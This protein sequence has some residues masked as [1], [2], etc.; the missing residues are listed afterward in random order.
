MSKYEL[1]EKDFE[2][3]FQAPFEAY[4]SDSPYVSL[5]KPDLERFLNKKENPL[6]SKYGDFTYFVVYRDQRPVGRIVAHIHHSSNERHSLKWSYFGFF[7]CDQDPQVAKMLLE[8]AENWGRAQGAKEIVGNMN[9][10]AMQQIGVMTDL[11]ENAP[12]S[13][14]V[15][16]PAHI[17]SH[18]ESH[19]YGKFFPSTTF[20]LDLTQFDS[21]SLLKGR[22]ATLKE[23]GT[24]QLKTPSR[25]GLAKYLE[26][27]RLVLN[28]GF[29]KNPFF[30][31]VTAE[32][33][34]FQAKDMMWVIDP[35]ITT[36]AYQGE[37]PVG[38]VICIPDLNPLLKATESRLSWKILSHYFRFRMNRKRA[39]IIYYSVTPDNHGQ[40]TA[41]L[42]LYE[43]V[44][45]LKASGY[46]KLAFTWIADE[47]IGSIRQTERLGAKPLHRL[48][49]FKK[50]L[51]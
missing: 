15:Y 16:S 5:F 7:D 36:F 32:E 11:F 33:F 49:L 25:W 20:E 40:G 28:A 42:M 10:T 12:Y 22:V 48:H 38:V 3:F 44:K 24:V 13:D 37:K 14:Q 50:D 29:D 41:G 47:N 6:F 39:V 1:R 19:G 51:A 8:A 45:A 17:A 2:G 30:V 9:L 23:S 4:G 31:P 46:E 18:L 35:R 21:E 26:H 27:A 34:H 43:T